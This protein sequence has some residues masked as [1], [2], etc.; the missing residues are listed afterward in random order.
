MIQAGASLFAP[1]IYPAT[2][3]ASKRRPHA[4]MG[5]HVYIYMYMDKSCSLNS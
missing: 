1:T 5:A 2:P 4:R 3:M